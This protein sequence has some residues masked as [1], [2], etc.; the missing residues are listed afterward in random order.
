ME[1]S[2][3]GF[4]VI[5]LSTFKKIRGKT[6]GEG[7]S[8]CLQHKT[9][10]LGRELTRNHKKYCRTGTTITKIKM[11]V[12]QIYINIKHDINIMLQLKEE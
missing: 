7:L 8:V 5:M 12:Y 1:L 9:E 2:D 6:D 10:N 3:K 4:R 11:S